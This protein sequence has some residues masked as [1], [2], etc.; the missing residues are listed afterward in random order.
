MLNA[1]F[2]A[3]KEFNSFLSN[4]IIE[5]SVKR[6]QIV[7]TFEDEL[8][9]T[10]SDLLKLNQI[11]DVL[12]I[13]DVTCFENRIYV[14][15]K[16]LS[17]ELMLQDGRHKDFVAIYNIIVFLRENLCTCP[18]LEYVLAEPYIKIFL[19]LPNVQLSDV[20]K[21]SSELKQDPFLEL[22]ADRPYLLYINEEYQEDV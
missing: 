8:M 7:L 2:N 12:N 5:I 10:F 3:I 6:S 14:S 9:I 18:A 17:E 13:T 20:N 16:K 21:V 11:D 19:D 15:Y 22:T 1:A 4:K